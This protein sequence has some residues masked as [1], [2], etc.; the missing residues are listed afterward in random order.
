MMSSNLVSQSPTGL[1]PTSLD[2]R[3]RSG[4]NLEFSS[5]RNGGN[6]LRLSPVQLQHSPPYYCPDDGRKVSADASEIICDESDQIEL[7]D[8]LQS[9]SPSRKRRRLSRGSHHQ[10]LELP[11]SPPPQRPMWDSRQGP[12]TRSRYSP[13]IRRS[14]YHQNTFAHTPVVMDVN[15][16]GKAFACCC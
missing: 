15:Q 1:V 8:F 10:I 6:E 12:M 16:V 9:E 5:R 3:P 2:V 7:I 11:P 13:S 4:L 14:R